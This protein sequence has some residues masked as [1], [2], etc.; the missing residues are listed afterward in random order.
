[1]AKMNE[2]QGIEKPEKDDYILI[3]EPNGTI[4]RVQMKHFMENNVV[5]INI[6]DNTLDY[7]GSEP[8]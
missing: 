3:M 6:P 5:V 2:I 7:G 8:V 1:M 4:R